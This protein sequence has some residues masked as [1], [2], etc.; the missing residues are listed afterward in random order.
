[1]HKYTYTHYKPARMRKSRKLPYSSDVQ[2]LRAS[3]QLSASVPTKSTYLRIT[4]QVKAKQNKAY[5]AYAQSKKNFKNCFGV[6]EQF[7]GRGV[8]TESERGDIILGKFKSIFHLLGEARGNPKIAEAAKVTTVP[9]SV[10]ISEQVV[11]DLSAPTKFKAAGP[12]GL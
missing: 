8:S 10:A 1:M 4:W 5:C 11:T 2:K 3:T 7:D 9:E 12:D 6:S